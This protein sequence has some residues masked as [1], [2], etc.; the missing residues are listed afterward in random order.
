MCN[1]PCFVPVQDDAE[2]MGLAFHRAPSDKVTTTETCQS[3]CNGNKKAQEGDVIAFEVIFSA[4]FV[5]I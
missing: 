4:N 3:Y 1:N 2:R 5:G